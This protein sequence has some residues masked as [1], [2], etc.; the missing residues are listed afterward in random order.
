[1]KKMVL[2]VRIN[3]YAMRNANPHVPWTADEG[4]PTR[5]REPQ[6]DAEGGR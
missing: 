3:E 4:Q 2:E 6:H 5:S 1:M